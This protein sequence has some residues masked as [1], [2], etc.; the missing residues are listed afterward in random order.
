MLLLSVEIQVIE[1]KKSHVD[2]SNCNA[3]SRDWFA[4]V[5]IWLVLYFFYQISPRIDYAFCLIY[6]AKVID[7]PINSA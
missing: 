5:A 3:I 6:C 2:I 4:R 7:Y 1:L